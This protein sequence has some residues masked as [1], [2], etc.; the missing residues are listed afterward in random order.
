MNDRSSTWALIF[1][2]SLLLTGC[3]ADPLDNVLSIKSGSKAAWNAWIDLGGLNVKNGNKLHGIEIESV[4][5]KYFS[6]GGKSGPSYIEMNTTA[7]PSEMRKVLSKL[8]NVS[9][10]DFTKVNNTSPS[11]AEAKVSH[12]GTNYTCYYE[13]SSSGKGNTMLILA[14]AK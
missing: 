9:E 2:T 6:D 13:M 11:A 12:N 1:T 10:N 14:S 7:S 3:F 4:S 8:C 5:S